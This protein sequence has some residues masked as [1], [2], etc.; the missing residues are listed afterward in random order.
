MNVS[1]FQTKQE[2]G[3]RAAARAA[4]ILRQCLAERGSANL[5]VATGASQFE[6]LSCLTQEPNIDWQRITA[7]HLDEYLGIPFTHPASFRG[8]LWQRFASRL[9][10]PL[11]AFHYI[12][13]EG[14][15]EAECQRVGSIIAK[16][17]IDLALVGIGENGHLAFNDPPADFD[18]DKP[19]LVVAL[20]EACR[21][22]QLGEGWFPTFDDVPTH[23]IS[24]SIRQIMRSRHIVC[25]VPDE[26]K[27]VA[28][29]ASIEGPVTNEMPASILQQHPQIEVFLDVPA[30]SRLKQQQTER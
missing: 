30:A 8:Y 12:N 13:G 1:V 24:M 4:E 19:Y 29:Q 28:V 25:T 23:A 14:D 17:P 7:F 2:L 15:A 10:I 27:A 18:T 16:H 11:G 6:M 5:I 21:R 22:Q 26:R 20:D 9:P 3:E